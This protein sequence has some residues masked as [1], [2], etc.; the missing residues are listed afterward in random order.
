M[1]G[2]SADDDEAKI[3]EFLKARL[4]ELIDDVWNKIV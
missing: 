2:M 1:V 4:D 3:Q